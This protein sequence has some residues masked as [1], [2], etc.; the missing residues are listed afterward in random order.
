MPEGAL[1]YANEATF[2]KPQ[3]HLRMGLVARETNRVIGGLEVSVPPPPPG[4]REVM[5]PHKNPKDGVQG[6]SGLTNTWRFGESA[7][8]PH[9]ALCVSYIRLF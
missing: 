2:G 7:P 8:S 5:E 4:S 3:S 1:C 9:P 6:A